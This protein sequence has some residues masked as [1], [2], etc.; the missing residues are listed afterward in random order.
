LLIIIRNAMM[1]RYP[2]MMKQILLRKFNIFYDREVRSY[3]IQI[4]YH[5]TCF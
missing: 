3:E 1:L 5:R 2:D 4:P